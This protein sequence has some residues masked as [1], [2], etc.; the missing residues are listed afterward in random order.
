MIALTAGKE[1][2]IFS[3]YPLIMCDSTYFQYW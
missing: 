3:C 1:I 2:Y